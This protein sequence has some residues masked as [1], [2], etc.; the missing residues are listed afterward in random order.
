MG[1]QHATTVRDGRRSIAVRR[2]VLQAVRDVNRELWVLNG[3]ECAWKGCHQRLLDEDR[4]WTGEIAHIVGAETGSA[5]HDPTWKPEKLRDIGNLA[6][7]CLHHT[8]IDHRDSRSNYPVEFLRKMKERHEAPFRR[9]Y[10]GFEEEFLN[11]TA[12][13]VVTPWTI[14]LA[15]NG[16][17]ASVARVADHDDGADQSGPVPGSRD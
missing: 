4:A 8:K 16:A 17:G 7:L 11:I 12:G 15:V 13:N 14:L 2:N 10:Q 9:A 1:P 3:S 5:S 6:L